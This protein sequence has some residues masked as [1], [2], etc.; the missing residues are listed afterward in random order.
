MTVLEREGLIKDVLK[1]NSDW[2]KQADKLDAPIY[3][4][5]KL[6]SETPGSIARNIR[7]RKQ[8]EDLSLQKLS[9][10]IGPGHGLR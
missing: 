8:K 3:A 7:K 1:L 4:H 6:G 5:L 2:K 9:P 10:V